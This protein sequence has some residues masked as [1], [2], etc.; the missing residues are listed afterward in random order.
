MTDQTEKPKLGTRPPLGS[1]ARSRPQ[2]QA[3]LRHG[4]SKRSW[5]RARSAASGSRE[6]PRLRRQA[7]AGGRTPTPAPRPARQHRARREE[8]DEISSRREL[9]EKLLREATRRACRSSRPRRRGR[10]SGREDRGRK[11]R[12]EDNR[13]R[14]R[15]PDQERAADAKGRRLRSSRRRRQ[16]AGA[17]RDDA[18]GA[19]S[20]VR[21]S[22]GNQ[23]SEPRGRRAATR[24]AA[25]RASSPSPAL[26]PAKMT[27][28]LAR[29]PRFAARA[30]RKNG[31][32]SRLA[33]LQSR[34]AMW[35]FPRRSP[36]KSWPTAWP[37]APPTW[38]RH[39][40][41]WACR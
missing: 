36:C 4:R 10:A 25:I 40:S 22:D 39:C 34:S 2:G 21:W 5:S 23:A 20:A 41:R 19:D 6:A 35:S 32:I 8:S 14:R 26:C 18:R 24:I 33:R 31:T 3:K 12:A 28:A 38:S 7:R 17:P 29:W 27:H 9:Q 30:K 1:S 11:T 13:A 16:R 15:A 37:S